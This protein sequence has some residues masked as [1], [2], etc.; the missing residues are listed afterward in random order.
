MDMQATDPFRTLLWT[1]T[2]IENMDE[3]KYPRTDPFM[4]SCP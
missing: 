3:C 4:V 1:P 2:K